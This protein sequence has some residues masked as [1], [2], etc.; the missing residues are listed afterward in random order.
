MLIAAGVG[1]VNVFVPGPEEQDAWQPLD[2]QWSFR[3]A[4]VEV[5]VPFYFPRPFVSLPWPGYVIALA[6]ILGGFI[7]AGLTIVIVLMRR[8][9]RTGHL[10]EYSLLDVS[11][12][13]DDD[14][15]LVEY[16]ALKI[17]NPPIGKG[18]YSVV[19]RA[20]L[21]GTVVAVKTFVGQDYYGDVRADFN[22][23]IALLTRLRHPNI[24]LFIGACRTPLC[25]IT[26]LAERGCLYDVINQVP[27]EMT[28][29]RIKSIAL[30]SCRGLAYLHNQTPPL[31]HRDLK[32]AN[33]LISESFVAKISDFGIAKRLAIHT[34]TM[35]V[36]TTRWMAPEVLTNKGSTMA[37]SLGS[38][39]Y[40]FAVV[41]WEML[42]LQLPWGKVTF[43]HQIEDRVTAG[44]HLPIPPSTPDCYRDLMESCFNFDAQQR[45][46]FTQLIFDIEAIPMIEGSPERDV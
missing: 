42:T 28:W 38:D 3:V 37:Y 33:V 32:S 35:R 40:S 13:L 10:I 41:I 12:Q 31:L 4:N 1:F 24:I 2:Q 26:E 25:I 9:G 44:E 17:Q 43:D 21:K 29:A 34:M 45:P 36:G 15:W 8:R 22:R 23:E 11:T 6:V 7:V 46:P 20:V 39:V 27:H 19:N 30:D 18:A 5:V 16:E 14:S